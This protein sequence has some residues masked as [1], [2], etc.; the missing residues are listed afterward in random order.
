MT[1]PET[2]IV[3]PDMKRS[4]FIDRLFP[5]VVMLALFWV[6]YG[7]AAI[8]EV[9]IISFLKHRERPKKLDPTFYL[10]LALAASVL[11]PC[12]A[13]WYIHKALY[14]ARH[15]ARVEGI[16][17]S[18]GVL[19]AAGSVDITYDYEFRYRRF[20]GKSGVPK[21]LVADHYAVGA[22]VILLVNPRRPD[23][24]KLWNDVFVSDETTEEPTEG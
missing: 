19:S 15:G 4:I 11:I 5:A 12:G 7:A 24:S 23:E 10:Y 9:D 3:S 8:F 20:S 6:L 1:N 13:A 2:R 16:V 22:T 17:R 18:V 14:F 21:A